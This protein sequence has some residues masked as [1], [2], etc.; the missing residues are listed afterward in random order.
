MHKIKKNIQEPVSR[1]ENEPFQKQMKRENPKK[2][3]DTKKRE[4]PKKKEKQG[5]QK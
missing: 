1:D 4:D 3:E 5:K 2:R